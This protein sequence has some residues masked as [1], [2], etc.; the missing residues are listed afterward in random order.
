MHDHGMCAARVRAAGARH[1]HLAIDIAGRTRD[2]SRA[3]G[4]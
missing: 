2:D 1:Q 3:R 4:A